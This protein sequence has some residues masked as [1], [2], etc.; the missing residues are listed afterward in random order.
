[1]SGE[2]ER[3]AKRTH[4]DGRPVDWFLPCDLGRA[5]LNGRQFIAAP[6]AG[7]SWMVGEEGRDDVEW[8]VVGHPATNS[9]LVIRARWESSGEGRWHYTVVDQ[10]DF[11]GSADE[12]AAWVGDY[13][14][15]YDPIEADDAEEE[16]VR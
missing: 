15:L 5:L 3:A 10:A 16:A 12:C 7:D 9:M 14:L 4:R 13:A 2:T 6:S 8:L 11:S 1:M